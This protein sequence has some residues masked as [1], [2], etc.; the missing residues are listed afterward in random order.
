MANDG[1][2]DS[3]VEGKVEHEASWR[4]RAKASHNVGKCNRYRTAVA[5]AGSTEYGYSLR[6]EPFDNGAHAFQGMLRCVF[7]DPCTEIEVG[8]LNLAARQSKYAGCA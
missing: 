4:K 8:P 3:V 2:V 6:L 5:V 7:R 1:N